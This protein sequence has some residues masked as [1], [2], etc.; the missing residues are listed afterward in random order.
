MG[1]CARSRRVGCERTQRRGVVDEGAVGL[2]RPIPFQ[3]RELGMVQRTPLAVAK[4]MRERKNP[5]LSGGEK[6]LAGEFGRRVQI[7]RRA[8][9][10]PLESGLKRSDMRLVARGDL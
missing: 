2:P 1:E 9:L 8:A 6:L 3:H 10:R 7:K 4:D 5:L